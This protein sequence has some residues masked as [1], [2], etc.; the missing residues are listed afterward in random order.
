M[1][2]RVHFKPGL[3]SHRSCALLRLSR[4]GGR[5]QCQEKRLMCIFLSVFFFL[6]KF[7]EVALVN[8]TVQVL[9]VQSYET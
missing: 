3:P 6:I 7:I 9:G 2:R 5:S 4:G 8:K 1:Q